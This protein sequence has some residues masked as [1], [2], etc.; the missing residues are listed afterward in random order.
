M[1]L[2]RG[3]SSPEVLRVQERLQDLGIFTGTPRGNFG[4]KTEVAI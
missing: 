3:M 4:E 1:N 2:K